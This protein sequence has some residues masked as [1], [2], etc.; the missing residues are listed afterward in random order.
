MSR[1]PLPKS[2]EPIESKSLREQVLD[3]LRSAIV[4]GELKPGQALVGSE[5]SSQ[6]GVSTATLREAVQTLIAEGLI[7]TSPYSVPTVKKLS[8]KDIEDLF[9]V[10]TMLEAF[11]I[12]QIIPSG[13]LEQVVQELQQIC[14]DMQQAAENNSLEE[15]NVSDRQF[16]DTLIRYSDNELLGVLWNSVAQRVRQVM[17]LRNRERDL[18]YIAKNHRTIVRAIKKGD[19]DKSV[20]LITEHVGTV[21]AAIAHSWEDDI[22]QES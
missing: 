12:Q 22:A 19:M 21:G 11:A 16:H 17:S 18:R 3:T 14:D 20:R 2:L 10:R 6:L 5:L 4:N 8:H 13:R 9:S 15:V 1:T 7:E